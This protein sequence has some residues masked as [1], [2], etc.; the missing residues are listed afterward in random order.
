MQGHPVGEDDFNDV[1]TI[2]YTGVYDELG[3]EIL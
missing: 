1:G 3:A 2:E